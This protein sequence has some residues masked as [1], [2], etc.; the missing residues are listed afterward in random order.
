[1]NFFLGTHQTVWLERT[2]V[3][4][5]VSHRRLRGR[6]RLPLPVGRWALDSGGF[7][8]L[9]IHGRWATSVAEYVDAA[10][11][12]L[13]EMP[14]LDW[15]APQDW[16]CEPQVLAQTGLTIV[17]HQRLTVHNLMALRAAAPELP[18]I[19]VLQGW[20]QADYHQHWAMY[21][22]AGIELGVEPLV[23]VGTV[24]RRQDGAEAARI[25][26]S[27]AD[28]GGRLHAFGLK[29]AGIAACGEA[30]VSADSMAW[31]FAA[32]RSPPLAGHTHSSCSN[33]MTWALAWRQ[34]VVSTRPHPRQHELS[35]GL[36]AGWAAT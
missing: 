27:L 16:M 21:A 4:L 31:S 9:S 3:P 32:R 6:R 19:P 20:Q 15:V 17:E 18:V 36:D 13:A 34:R 11:R 7:T 26:R 8:E 25:I 22:A 30:L 2:C 33:C 28:R 35:L 29:R 5:F 12:Y 14:G 24:C 23:G 10:R 1:M